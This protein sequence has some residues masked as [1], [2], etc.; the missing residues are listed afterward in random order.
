[1]TGATDD[2]GTFP[3][4]SIK[5]K[6][7]DIN[8]S[9]N[10]GGSAEPNEMRLKAAGDLQA[11]PGSKLFAVE[12]GVSRDPF[13]AVVTPAHTSTTTGASSTDST[14]TAALTRF[15]PEAQTESD[16]YISPI[17]RN[18]RLFFQA[19]VEL[20]GELRNAIYEEIMEAFMPPQTFIENPGQRLE[21][22]TEGHA[23]DNLKVGKPLLE[24]IK[25]ILCSPRYRLRSI[26]KR[27]KKNI[28]RKGR[29]EILVGFRN[30][31]LRAV[32]MLRR[33]FL[34]FF[35]N[36][37]DVHFCTS[38]PELYQI[39]HVFNF[40]QHIKLITFD[41]HE[42]YLLK[43]LNK[44]GCI[45]Q[46]V[47]ALEKSAFVGDIRILGSALGVKAVDD[48]L[49]RVL[50]Y[51]NYG[52]TAKNACQAVQ[53]AD[54]PWKHM[55]KTFCDRTDEE[56]AESPNAFL[57]RPMDMRLSTRTKGLRLNKK[58][59]PVMVFEGGRTKRQLTDEE[60]EEVLPSRHIDL[61][62]KS[63]QRDRQARLITEQEFYV[64]IAYYK[65][66]YPDD[67]GLLTYY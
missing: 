27:D 42:M 47:V 7:S 44:M 10:S 34:D 63:Y 14:A 8:D 18:T 19:I 41:V 31:A 50:I 30:C 54:S 35:W 17:D 64:R 1:M 20:P 21:D 13:S 32:P 2:R 62:I 43:L 33:E 45:R 4:R 56:R 55:I 60:L 12:K 40:L 22:L 24:L 5:H 57:I 3:P 25:C 61:L 46:L 58:K 11:V 6:R 49:E 26:S 9:G 67:K 23:R 59:R 15:L 48:T 65:E 66:R 52:N 38:L 29:S 16:D 28:A 36:Q 39:P 37:F 51:W 53:L